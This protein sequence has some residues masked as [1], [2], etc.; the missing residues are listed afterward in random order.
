MSNST[1]TPDGFADGLRRVTRRALKKLQPR[2]LAR[3][4]GPHPPSAFAKPAHHDV[5]H[6][7]PALPEANETPEPA[8]QLDGEARFDAFE[9][10]LRRIEMATLTL[11]L[12]M[13]NVARAQT[14][15]RG[16]IVER[17]DRI[18]P[19]ERH[20]AAIPTPVHPP[21][22]FRGFNGHEITPQTMLIWLAIPK[23]ATTS[24]AEILIPRLVDRG[25]GFNAM[26]VHRDLGV[27]RQRTSTLGIQQEWSIAHLWALASEQE[28]RSASFTGGH[29]PYGIHPIF[30]PRQC[31][32]L[33]F[34][35]HPVALAQSYYAFF[36]Q[37]LPSYRQA[38]QEGMTLK[39]AIEE[40]RMVGLF[41][42]QTRV[43][44]GMPEL[45]P[46]GEE[47]FFSA[48]TCAVPRVALERAK[49][50][51]VKDF[52]LV[53]I[54]EEYSKSLLMLRRMLGWRLEDTLGARRKIGV[55]ASPE[56]ASDNAELHALLCE[57]NAL[58]LE[59]YDF[60][61]DLFLSR[62]RSIEGDVGH[63]ERFLDVSEHFVSAQSDAEAERIA[64]DLVR[65]QARLMEACD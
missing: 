61:R 55:R 2:W 58:D 36:C 10:R 65:G 54:T 22:P 18:A 38:A 23:T 17:L 41:N 46:D 29:I 40:K 49:E 30:A 7:A 6:E 12:Q 63:L 52:C 9:E 28:R 51:L 45:R 26:D 24:L 14:R 19:P 64:L 50:N 13:H 25:R 5:P 48:E 53:G 34:L 59:L 47:T 43:L 21:P 11:H 31:S 56:T 32:Y 39:S 35:R 44:S 33:T 8:Q 16:D 27:D 4:R 37:E 15:Q 42:L 57:A 20:V 60:A 1:F 62:W 3:R